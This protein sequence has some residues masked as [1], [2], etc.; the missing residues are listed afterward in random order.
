MNDLPA[1]YTWTLNV[2]FYRCTIYLLCI[3]EHIMWHF[4]AERS[5]CYVYMNTKCHTSQ[6]NDLASMYT[7]TPNVRLYSCMIYLLCIHEHL[8]SDFTGERST[9]YVY[10]NTKCHTLQVNDLASMYTWTPNVRL[11]SWMIYLLCIHEHLISDFTGERYTC[12]V[13]MKT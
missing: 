6:V 12:Y 2:R 7:W 10:M 1:M 8:I 4:T 11:Y 13:Y 9:C 5:T 3:H